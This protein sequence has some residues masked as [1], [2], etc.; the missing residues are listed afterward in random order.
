MDYNIMLDVDSYKV[1]MWKQYPPGT[2]YVY[3]Y[4]ESRGGRY[5]ETLFFGL[6]SYIRKYLSKPITQEQIDFAEKFWIAHSGYFN[7]EGW[8]YILKEHNGYLPIQVMSVSEGGVY[9][10]GTPL[11]TVMNIDPKVPW[12][13]TWIETSMLRAVWYQT[14]VA[15]QSFSIKKL[16]KEYLVKSGDVS[17]LPFKLHDFG[18][19]GVSSLESGTLGAMS[20]LV[21]FMGSDTGVGALAAHEFYDAPLFATCFSIP[22][23]EHSTITSWG[24]DKEALAYENMIRQFSKEGSIYAVV[25]D[26][27]DIF[28]AVENIWGKQ[29]K[30]LIIEKKG[31]L[32][33]RPD[34]GDPVEVLPRLIR[35]LYK[36]FGG[37]VNDK[38][39]IVLNNVR[40]I[41]GD[42]IDELTIRAILCLIVDMMGF[43]VDNIAFGMGG[44]LLQRLDRDT[45]KF[46][47]K[48]SA[49]YINKKWVEVFKDPITDSGKRSKKG[50]L[51]ETNMELR[52]WNGVSKNEVTF[53]EVKELAESFC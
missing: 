43:S 21:N 22:A 31:T 25:S 52:F 41:W 48:C 44:A 4:I 37:V 6:Q 8:E 17:L 19:R 40:L 11:V 7:R 29:L 33:I 39:Y 28:N 16:I 3:S 45:Q 27:Y 32:V 20:H 38:G 42:G 9:P 51:D 26:S 13:T 36:N 2:E 46:A 23:A 12:L 47:M 18:L 30:D 53:Q 50:L 15:T 35:S 5:P 34:S 49:A 14:T 10:V 1:G 24:R